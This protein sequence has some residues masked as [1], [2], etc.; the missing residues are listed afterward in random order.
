MT[1]QVANKIIWHL[2]RLRCMVMDYTVC[3]WQQAVLR[4]WCKRFLTPYTSLEWMN[5]KSIYRAL[6]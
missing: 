5:I 3:I 6:C 2:N 1:K 4:A